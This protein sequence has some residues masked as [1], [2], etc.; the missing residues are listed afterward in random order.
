MLFALQGTP[1]GVEEKDGRLTRV[2]AF[3][4]GIDPER[5]KEALDTPEVQQ[6]VTSLLGRY[7]GRKVSW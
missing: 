7:G 5:F 3:P 4:I 2:A 6:H 1:E